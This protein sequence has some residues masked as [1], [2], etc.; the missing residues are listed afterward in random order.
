MSQVRR[1]TA[2]LLGVLATT[3]VAAAPAQAGSPAEVTVAKAVGGPYQENQSASVG[4]GKTK[5]FYWR[6]GAT[7]TNDA[8]AVFD[9]AATGDSDTGYKIS[10]YK[11]KKPKASNKISSDVKNDGYEFSLKAGSVKYFT[12]KVK[13]VVPDPDPLCMGGQVEYFGYF[14][15]AYMSVNGACL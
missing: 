15:A 9:D 6:V 3:A 11:G 7:V 2:T 4:E 13:S 14:S 5:L 8:T 12:G 10:W 1:V